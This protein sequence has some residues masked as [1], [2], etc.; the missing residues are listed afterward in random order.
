MLQTGGAKKSSSSFA[1]VPRRKEGVLYHP[2][3]KRLDAN[4][5]LTARYQDRRK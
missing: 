3:P 4:K 5:A 1:A 2:L